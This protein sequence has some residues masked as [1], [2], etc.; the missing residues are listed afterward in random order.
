[1][2]DELNETP[3]EAAATESA[4]APAASAA[5]AAQTSDVEA[6]TA[7]IVAEAAADRAA[8]EAESAAAGDDAH[9]DPYLDKEDDSTSAA[10]QPAEGEENAEAK[11]KDAGDI[12]VEEFEQSLKG[13]EGKWYVL[14]TYSG[15]EKRVK[16][17]VESRIQSFNLEDSVFQV[18][19]PME[20]FEQ[21]N[22]KGKKVSTRVLIPGYVLIRMWPDEDARRIIRD[23]EGVTGFVGPD[24]MPTPLMRKE[25]VQMMAPMIR[26]QALKDAGETP[27]AAKNRVVEVSYEVGQ[28]VTV[29]DG[30][31]TSMPASISEVHPDTQKLTV[32]VNLFG[33]ETPVE[34][35]FDQ[36]EKLD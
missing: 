14:H 30:P 11:P 33:R 13:L 22:E 9:M 32:L 21:H 16:A 26:T 6:A 18:E 28:Q 36:V 27:A 31:F 7:K 4:A 15:Y 35:G 1:M 3:A 24:H 23:T 29:T 19:V 25:V 17:N 20:E 5:P 12:A 2:T 10:A 8:A 34:L